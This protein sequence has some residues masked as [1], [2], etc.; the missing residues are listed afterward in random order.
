MAVVIMIGIMIFLP[1]TSKAMHFVARWG[2]DILFIRCLADWTPL[3]AT[4]IDNGLRGHK[5][6]WWKGRGNDAT[7]GHGREGWQYVIVSCRLRSTGRSRSSP[8]TSSHSSTAFVVMKAAWTTDNTST[9]GLHFGLSGNGTN[10]GFT[11]WMFTAATVVE[12]DWRINQTG[13]GRNAR[14][15]QNVVVV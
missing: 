15:V 9:T 5:R 3:A 4:R 13:F 11:F 7:C 2:R 8:R 14:L 6:R 10:A 12:R 1:A